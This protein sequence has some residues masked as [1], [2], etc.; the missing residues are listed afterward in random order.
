MVSTCAN[1]SCSTPLR[2]LRDGRIYQF[3]VRTCT[4]SDG[5][6]EAASQRGKKTSRRVDHFW[7]CGN[8]SSHLTL[9]FDPLGGVKAVP[10]E[11]PLPMGPALPNAYQAS[12]E[13]QT[14]Y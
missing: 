14:G 8:C 6:S 1:P 9:V 10:M 4:S 5:A 7:L 2:Y 3:E 11:Q 12:V 13:S